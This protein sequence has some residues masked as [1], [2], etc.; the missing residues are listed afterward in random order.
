LLTL[1]GALAFALLLPGVMDAWGGGSFGKRIAGLRMVTRNGARPGLFRSLL[2]HSVKFGMNLAV[3]VVF[4][5]VERMVLRG[6][7]LHEMLS[8]TRVVWRHATDRPT[9]MW[10]VVGSTLLP[11]VLLSIGMQTLTG[12]SGAAQTSAIRKAWAASL[13]L[14]TAAAEHL[15]A[16]GKFP[17]REALPI[18][19]GQHVESIDAHTGRLVVMLDQGPSVGSLLVFWPERSTQDATRIL[20]WRCATERMK[21]PSHRPDIGGGQCRSVALRSP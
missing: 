8:G 13:P 5:L 4:H 6:H 19:A 7:H 9:L 14:K 2:R 20:R 12:Q 10:W 18:V 21:E 11:L 3:P 1:L 17:T 16:E 15:M